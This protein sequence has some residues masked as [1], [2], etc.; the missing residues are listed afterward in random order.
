MRKELVETH[1]V[2]VTHAAGRRGGAGGTVASSSA[3]RAPGTSRAN[4]WVPTISRSAS[5]RPR[6][7]GGSRDARARVRAPRPERSRGGTRGTETVDDA[8]AGAVASGARWEVGECSFS[9]HDKTMTNWGADDVPVGRRHPSRAA[10]A[11]RVDVRRAVWRAL[12]SRP[13]VL[14]RLG[15]LAAS[16]DRR[17]AADDEVRPLSFTPAAG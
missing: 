9:A 7:G 13:R 12:D 8:I 16:L 5:R 15:A 6:G 14:V 17:V 4:A 10:A 11:A 2:P 3:A 1:E